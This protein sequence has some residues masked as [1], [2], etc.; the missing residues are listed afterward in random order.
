MW[1]F[2]AFVRSKSSISFSE[3]W[4]FK[5]LSFLSSSNLAL[6]V[7]VGYNTKSVNQSKVNGCLRVCMSV[8]IP[9]Y[10]SKGSF[11]ISNLLLNSGIARRDLAVRLA[12]FALQVVWCWCHCSSTKIK[13][14]KKKKILSIPNPIILTSHAWSWP[15]PSAALI[16]QGLTTLYHPESMP[17]ES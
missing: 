12:I 8:L 7:K 5:A 16:C 11:R 15:V 3:E 6:A 14:I 9:T 2:F 13:Y 17:C 10:T 1:Y 4:K